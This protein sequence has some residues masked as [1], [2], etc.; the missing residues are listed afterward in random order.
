MAKK[1]ADTII[2]CHLHADADAFSSMYGASKLFP[3]ATLLWPGSPNTLIET[4]VHR[5]A[6]SSSPALAAPKNKDNKPNNDNKLSPSPSDS[7][8]TA[9]ANV[10]GSVPSMS[11][12]L[13]YDASEHSLD[14]IFSLHDVDISHVK[15][16]VVVDTHSASRIKHAAELLER[17]KKGETE[18]FVWDHHPNRDDDIHTLAAPSNAVVEIVGSCSSLLIREIAA[19]EQ[20]GEVIPL[21]PQEATW[22]ALGIYEDTGGFLYDSVT[23]VDYISASY[24]RSKGLDLRFVSDYMMRFRPAT[25]MSSLNDEDVRVYKTLVESCKTYTIRD[26]T[27]AIATVQADSEPKGFAHLCQKVVEEKGLPCLFVVGNFEQVLLVARAKEK[28]YIACG[29]IM[30]AFGGGGHDCAASARAK[31]LTALEA[32]EKLFG[33]ILAQL[34]PDM[35]SV[36]SLMNSPVVTINSDQSINEAVETFTNLNLK[37]LPVLDRESRKVVGIID[38]VISEKAVKHQLGTQLVSDLME[39]QFETLPLEAHGA[40]AMEL[41]LGT[42]QRMVPVVNEQ[43]E[44]VGVVSRADVVEILM[45]EPARFPTYLTQKKE[46]NIGGLARSRL[47]KDIVRFLR[48]AGELGDSLGFNV[49]VVGGFVRDLIM[50]RDNDD[51]DLVVEGDGVLFADK[52]CEGYGVGKA[53]HHQQFKT[54]VVTLKSGLKVDVTT[55]RLEYYPQPVSLPT[56]EMSSLKMDLYR[57]D[58][59][60]NAMAMQLNQKSFGRLMDFF[61]GHRDIT[62]GSVSVLH[63]LSFVE[64]PTRIFR[65]IRFEQR[66]N[67]KI[68][69]Q[70]DRLIKSSLKLNIMDKLS[71][72]RIFHELCKIVEDEKPV[73]CFRRLQ[74]PFKILTAIHPHLE[75]ISLTS[76]EKAVDVLKLFRLLKLRDVQPTTWKLFFLVF[77]NSMQWDQL[78]AVLQRL[79]VQEGT[80]TELKETF[81][82]ATNVLNDLKGI[83]GRGTYKPSEVYFLLKGLSIEGI[84]YVMVFLDTPEG[85]K[86]LISYLTHMQYQK[87]DITGNDLKAMGYKPSKKFAV[88]LKEVLRV[89]LDGE[90]GGKEAQLELAKKL[91]DQQ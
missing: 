25:D 20:R 11:K 77:F 34:E 78:K 26:K 14:I 28:G 83:L 90:V 79:L 82:L 13:T 42:R 18:L 3:S 61:H 68:S 40:V 21:T 5:L 36:S 19:R 75:K 9:A 71:G 91:M 76:M 85:R 88:V 56:V 74:Q 27:V 32:E 1:V 89:V 15:R 44:V 72:A 10:T 43:Q 59:T 54:A 70:T 39:T 12:M 66:Y 37:R 67:F 58:F 38:R 53:T 22:L 46:H 65:A 80:Q 62:T 29:E 31:G 23:P 35:L 84:L 48:N 55:A 33:L 87:A 73:E 86:V 8:T 81:A 45:K 69:H 64:D 16:F 4:L 51:I 57:R 60:M 49:Y 6:A 24:L 41:V 50:N 30:S 7:P 52:L 63:S 17:V 2:T 47:P